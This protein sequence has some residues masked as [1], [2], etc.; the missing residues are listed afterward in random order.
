MTKRNAIRASRS[1]RQHALVLRKAQEGNRRS[2]A[3]AQRPSLYNAQRI[4][5]MAT[6]ERALALTFV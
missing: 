6:V 2:T 3:P 1:T 4:L 5:N